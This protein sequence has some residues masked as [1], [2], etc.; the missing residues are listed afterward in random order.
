[1]DDLADWAI[2]SPI[3]AARARMIDCALLIGET[4]GLTR[5]KTS[6]KWRAQLR[7]SPDGGRL[8]SPEQ[9]RRPNLFGPVNVNDKK[10]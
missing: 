4:A 5:Q 6:K 2:A 10:F 1:M 3:D 8:T 7:A 9:R